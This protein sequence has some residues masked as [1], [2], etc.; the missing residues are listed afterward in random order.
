MIFKFVIPYNRLKKNLAS[1]G[2]ETYVNLYKT[3]PNSYNY[4]ILFI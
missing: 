1:F 2:R 3:V 4:M